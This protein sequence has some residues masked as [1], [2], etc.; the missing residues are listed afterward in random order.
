MRNINDAV[1]GTRRRRVFQ[2][3]GGFTLCLLV[4]IAQ[5]D[6]VSV[7]VLSYDTFIPAGDGSPGVLAFDLANLTGAFSLPTD[8]PVTN[9]LTFESA[10]LTLTLSDLTQDVIA[11]GD[12]GPG[13]LL[14]QSGNPIVQVPGNEMFDSAEFTATLSPSHVFPLRRHAV[15]S[16]FDFD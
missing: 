1:S 15:H 14:D 6:T 16:R 4:S 13:F 10:T 8:L 3:L 2:L 7:G 12:I 11:L 9:S 5:A